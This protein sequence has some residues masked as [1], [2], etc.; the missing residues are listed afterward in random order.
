M[1]VKKP[2]KLLL[3]TDSAIVHTGLA[4]TTR[5]VFRRMLEKFPGKYEIEQLGWFHMPGHRSAEEVP[6]KIHPTRMTEQGF[7]PADKY[8]Q[9]S[10]EK[11]RAEFKPDIVY[12][13]GDLWCFDHLLNSPTRNT[14][15]LITYYTIDGEP[16]YGHDFHPNKSSA[17]GTKL[18][19][20]D[21][22]V[23]LSEYGKHVLTHSCPELKE[24]DP[25]VIYHPVD[26]QRFNPVQ[27]D[28]LQEYRRS[29]YASGIPTDAFIMGWI[30]RNQFRKQNYKMW[31]TLHHIKHG[32][33]IECEECGRVTRK[34]IDRATRVARP[35]GKLR[36]YDPDY[37]YKTC[38]YCS[39]SNIL[40]GQPLD[41]VL[42]WMHMNKTDPGW[43]VPDLVHQWDIAD[44]IIHPSYI[45]QAF[46]L[47]PEELAQL[48]A[49]WDCMLYLSGGEGFGIPPYE[50]MASG[51]PV[52]YSNYSSHADFCQ[53]GGLPVR[54]DLIPELAF[55]INRALADVND[56]IAKVLWGY[57]NRRAFKAL[58]L[59][60]REWCES[61]SIDAIVDQ[62]DA[63][64]TETM[65]QEVGINST[66]RLYAEII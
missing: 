3:S 54:C 9:Q 15:R 16:Y 48:I 55:S 59:K 51:I 52:I 21:R 43:K 56:A 42:L 20:A 10:F 45:E 12:V 46:G 36:L 6:W 35:V 32:D 33:Y 58:G 7:D 8:G 22:V 34:E 19:R 29:I 4:E 5:L 66:E 31:E 64:F 14:F 23:V 65:K 18:S 28:D 25:T 44:K 50:S 37:D 11:V 62:W 57:R 26:L 40:E 30:G 27:Y 47:K 2:I 24:D 63:V 53:H 38:W 61:K 1:T 17:W 39:S 41:D 49:S 13:N 60:G